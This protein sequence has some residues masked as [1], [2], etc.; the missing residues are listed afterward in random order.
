VTRRQKGKGS[1]RRKGW[2]R[3][4]VEADRLERALRLLPD[5]C[6]GADP[7]DGEP[8]PL[9]RDSGSSRLHGDTV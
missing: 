7:T 2:H 6:S 3:G 4:Q 9:R 8:V 5:V 1:K